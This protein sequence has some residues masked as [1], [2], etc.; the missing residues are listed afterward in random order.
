MSS[1]KRGRERFRLS[2]KL[3]VQVIEGFSTPFTRLVNAVTGTKGLEKSGAGIQFRRAK[4]ENG[5]P[6]ALCMAYS[7]FLPTPDNPIS[8]LI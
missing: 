4:M 3:P 5:R 6:V 2:A 7:V 8:E 1:E